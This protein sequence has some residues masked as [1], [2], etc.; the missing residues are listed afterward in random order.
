MKN[1]VQY[2]TVSIALL[3]VFSC[4]NDF[5]NDEPAFFGNGSPIV[6]SP[7]WETQD[8][9][10]YCEGVGNAKFTVTYAPSWLK[11]SS[12][13]GQ[14]INNVAV[15]NC[16]ANVNKDFFEIG[17]YHSFVTLS[18]EGRGNLAIPLSYITEGNP[19]IETETRLNVNYDNMPG[20]LLLFP[21]QNTGNGIL[22]WEVVQHPEWL[23]FYSDMWGT[24]YENEIIGILP[25]NQTVNLYYSFN[26][27]VSLSENLSGKI[28]I[29]SNDKNN[30]FVEIEIQM[31][32]GNPIF[33][34]NYD[35][36]L[37]FRTETTQNFWFSNQGNGILV[38][39][40]EG[41]PEWLTVS[42]SNGILTSHNPALLSFTCNRE[43]L[44]SGTNSITIYLKTNDK[45][46]LSYPITVIVRSNTANPANIIEI[47]GNITD[48]SMNRQSD[49]LYLSTR[50][51]NRLLAYDTKTRTIVCEVPLDYAPTC[52]SLSDDGRKAVV[53][54]GG[55]IT[56]VDLDDCSVIK[57]VDVPH[58]VYDIE[59]GK[60][61]WCC[62][63]VP[64]VQW[65]SL[66]WVNLDTN[67][68]N[69][70]DQ[71]YENCRL[72]KIPNQDYIFGAEVNVSA[73]VYIFDMNSRKRKDSNFSYIG[74]FWFSEDGNY[75]YSLGGDIYR[76]S[77]FFVDYY[78]YEA[79]PI[80]KFSPVP[81]RVFW[82]DHHAASQSIWI[83]SSS[84]DYYFD[85]QREIIQYEDNDYTRKAIWYYDEYHNG[86]H[87]Q[88]HYVFAT[89]SGTELVVI[90]N[91]TNGEPM[92][93][94]EFI[95]IEE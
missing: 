92:W 93:S 7:D 77:S 82:I 24:I 46:Q 20:N 29:A 67:E 53:G 41:C 60:D 80:G 18:V 90:R 95:P 61:N 23:S 51:P 57:I 87:V 76:T 16:K 27:N 71:I 69:N 35:N 47:A 49:I 56:S 62:Y 85:E 75:T 59:W 73:G 8:Y 94:L 72:R 52:F 55:Y 38:W 22:I 44:P 91:V 65:T 58:I 14:I 11:I 25:F 37:N 42:E 6:I 66:Y 45:N 33:Y 83:L 68:K 19:V 21:I 31:S 4:N 12:S 32:L 30:P 13:S 48:A 1:L 34:T 40:I 63:S 88:A 36:T 74:D 5:L 64:N 28:V 79:A 26:P 3:V 9:T 54:H 15:L 17:I 50:Q 84:S 70:F 39:T 2:I 89:K 81:Y 43:L 86:R 10:I 78:A